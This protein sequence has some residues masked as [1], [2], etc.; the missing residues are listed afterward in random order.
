MY[1]C[2]VAIVL[3]ELQRLRAWKSYQNLLFIKLMNISCR[4]GCIWHSREGTV[5]V[6]KYCQMFTK[7]RVGSHSD[8]RKTTTGSIECFF[9]FIETSL[10]LNVSRSN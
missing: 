10:M 2:A 5:I 8:K 3:A 6:T 1:L 4:K 7:Y 9:R